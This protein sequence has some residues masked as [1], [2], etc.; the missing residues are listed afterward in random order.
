G[1]LAPGQRDHF[2]GTHALETGDFDTARIRFERVVERL[3]ASGASW[4]SLS[5]LPAADDAGLLRRL[6]AAAA[7]IEAGDASH[8]AQWQYA[9]GTVL[10]RLGDRDGAF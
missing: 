5:A 3:P 7:A 10:D 8:R 1:Q 2:L 9:R 4:L 6:D